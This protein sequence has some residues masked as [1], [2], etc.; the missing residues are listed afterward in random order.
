MGMIG[1]QILDAVAMLPQWIWEYRDQL[2]VAALVALLL[3]V[4]SNGYFLKR[5][6]GYGSRIRKSEDD[7]AAEAGPHA[8]RSWPF[9]SVL[10]PARNE[11]DNI[12]RC[13]ASLVGQKYPRFEVIVLDD[14][15]TDGTLGILHRLALSSRQLRVLSGRPLPPDWL[16][17]HW[18]CHQLA[19]ASKG[20][21]LLFTD[22]DTCHHPLM[23]EDV[24]AAQQM[25]DSDLLT[26][27]P[28]EEVGSWG[29]IL[30]LPIINW[31]MAS[32]LPVGLAH[33]LKSP[34]LSMGIGQFMLFRRSGYLA[35][36]GF[37]AVR[38]DPVDD[39]A[40]ARLTKE[41]GLRWRF[42]DLSRRV[43]CRMYTGFRAVADGL[44]K[45]VFPALRNSVWAL[46]A[47]VLLLAW[48]YL[49][50]LGVAASWLLGFSPDVA[51]LM[52][53]GSAIGLA[54]AGWG[55]CLWRFGHPWYRAVFYPASIALVIGIAL[56]SATLFWRGEACWKGRALPGLDSDG[57]REERRSAD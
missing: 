2:R 44:G 18:A 13:V 50:P 23:L 34:T 54:L 28:H 40:L 41:R 49:G 51:T 55:L 10:V 14:D 33:R 57:S 26:G 48:L 4:L 6:D 29:E 24:V 20:E 15:S 46:G 17:K 8:P 7:A 25:E 9:V 12:E 16:G 19:Q 35:I 53:A 52:W 22:A 30:V 11:E 38:T 43:S 1:W 42:V 36:G 31:A 3:V 39:V 47:A 21:L 32:L 56:R 27:I 45:S 37:A 5:L